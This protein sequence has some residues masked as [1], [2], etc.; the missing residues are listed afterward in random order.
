M[1]ITIS[2]VMIVLF[3][4]ACDVKEIY[5]AIRQIIPFRRWVTYVH[6]CM[7]VCS[8]NSNRSFNIKHMYVYKHIVS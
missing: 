8:I 7:Y 5:S 1:Q 3:A 2:N 6:V 4:L